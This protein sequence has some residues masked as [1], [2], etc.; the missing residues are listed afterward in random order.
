MSLPDTLLAEPYYSIPVVD[1]Q[2]YL[3]HAVEGEALLKGLTQLKGASILIRHQYERYDGSGFPDSLAKQ[4]IP[5]GSRILNVVGDYIAYLEGAMTGEV[6]SVSAAINQLM[7]RKESYYDP[8]IIDAFVKVLKDTTIEEEVVVELP[9]VKKSWKNSKL[10]GGASAAME[11]PVIEIS[12]MQ[13]KPGM[14]VDSVYFENKHYIKN[15]IVDQKIINNINSLRE[16]T[17]KNP[18][19]KIRM[20]AK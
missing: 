4:N 8:D 13:L 10:F 15:C 11:R 7:S 14:E 16:N 18:V 17:G 6:M 20:G 19:I 9:A 12:W 5:L 2:R 1:K 3:K